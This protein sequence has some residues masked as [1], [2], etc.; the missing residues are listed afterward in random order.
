MRNHFLITRCEIHL[1]LCASAAS[2]RQIA[3]VCV[4]VSDC[5]YV[6]IE[7]NPTSFTSALQQLNIS[8][9]GNRDRAHVR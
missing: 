9:R 3:P 1:Y 4:C 8:K 7:I 2:I 6:V 5:V